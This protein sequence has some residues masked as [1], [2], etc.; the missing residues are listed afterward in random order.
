MCSQSV[1]TIQGSYVW[2]VCMKFLEH[3]NSKNV[4]TQESKLWNISVIN[5]AYYVYELIEDR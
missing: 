5:N 3:S 4:G 2:N 1:F